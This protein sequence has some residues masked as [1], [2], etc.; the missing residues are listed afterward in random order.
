MIQVS[1]DCRIKSLGLPSEN[2]FF[3][4]ASQFKA[5]GI[6]TRN[7][8]TTDHQVVIVACHENDVGSEKFEFFNFPSGSEILRETPGRIANGTVYDNTLVQNRF[9]FRL[10]KRKALL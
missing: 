3:C 1:P 8:K 2:F 9:D 6:E 5:L 7:I 10:S 4:L